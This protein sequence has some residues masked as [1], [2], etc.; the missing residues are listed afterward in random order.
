[1]YMYKICILAINKANFLINSLFPF[2]VA[3]FQVPIDMHFVPPIDKFSL[4][5][6]TCRHHC[7]KHNVHIKVSDKYWVVD[8]SE[9]LQCKVAVTF[10]WNHSF[11]PG[12]VFVGPIIFVSI[13]SKR[14]C[15]V[16]LRLPHALNLSSSDPNKV[17]R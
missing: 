6:E 13:R 9:V 7:E 4:T 12:Y 16:K 8:A 10:Q 1:M 17:L 14:S 15:G 2:L 3:A 5:N 11:P